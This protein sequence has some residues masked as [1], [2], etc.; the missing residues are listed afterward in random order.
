MLKITDKTVEITTSGFCNIRCTKYC[1][2]E[3]YAR[4]YKGCTFLTRETYRKILNNIGTDTKVVFAGFSEPFLSKDCADMVKDTYNA[5]Y[6]VS[7]FTTLDGVTLDQI[8]DLCENVEFET[9]TVHLPDPEHNAGITVN[10]EYKDVFFYVIQHAPMAVLAIMNGFFQSNNRENYNRGLVTGRK[11]YPVKCGKLKHGIPVVLP[12]GDAVVCCHD[13]ALKYPVG[14]LLTTHLD[15]I[16]T[17][18]AFR[19]IKRSNLNPFS[20]YSLCKK[21][22]ESDIFI[23]GPIPYTVKK[24]LNKKYLRFENSNYP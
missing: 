7:L 11:W 23:P 5:G 17:G 13:F 4:N 21:C 8:K 9:L 2:H 16:L 19:K 6:S 1:P 18:P 15:D 12:N 14:N 22:T 3:V 20:S 10:Q 24:Y